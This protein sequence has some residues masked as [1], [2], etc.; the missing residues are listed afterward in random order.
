MCCLELFGKD[1]RYLTIALEV[2]AGTH[3]AM[4]TIECVCPET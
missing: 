4:T 3:T 1:T 2:R